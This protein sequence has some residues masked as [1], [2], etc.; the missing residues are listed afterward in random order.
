MATLTDFAKI[1]L[2]PSETFD[3]EVESAN[4][5]RGGPKYRVRN[6]QVLQKLNATLLFVTAQDSDGF[7][8]WY[9]TE[10]KRI[11]PFPI[12]HPRTGQTLM[13]NFEKGNIGTLTSQAVQFHYGQRD[14]VLEYLR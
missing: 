5:E 7:E 2:N 1:R 14:V 9:F 3:P 12:V 6:S 4:M 11:N 13:V 10:V 8:A